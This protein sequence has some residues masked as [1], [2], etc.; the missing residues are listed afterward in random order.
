MARHRDSGHPQIAECD[1]VAVVKVGVVLRK[2]GWCTRGS[3]AATTAR[4][5]ILHQIP[6]CHRY[7]HLRSEV[8]LKIRRTTEVIGVPVRHE[9]DL[10][11]RWIETRASENRAGAA[12]PV[13]PPCP[14]HRLPRARRSASILPTFEGHT[15]WS[16]CCRSRTRRRRSSSAGS[17]DRRGG[18]PSAPRTR[19]ARHWPSGDRRSASDARSCALM[20]GVSGFAARRRLRPTAWPASRSRIPRCHGVAWSPLFSS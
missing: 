16:R 8:F 14:P 4:R 7:I 6:V 3:T 18:S 12:S 2:R 5:R 1:G 19:N 20:S 17:A 15:P 9:H 13:V 10:H 11:L